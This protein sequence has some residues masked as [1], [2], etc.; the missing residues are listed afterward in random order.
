MK[1]CSRSNSRSGRFDE[2]GAFW[3]KDGAQIYFT[4]LHVDEPYYERPKTE[5]YSVSSNG[6]DATKLNSFDMDVNNMS[7]SPD[8]KQIAF[9]ASATQPVN[10]YTQPDLWVV[11]LT[12][13]A[14]PRNL[15]EKFDF[16]LGSGRFGDKRTPRAGGG[17]VPI[18]TPDGRSLIEIYGKEGKTI[19]ASFDVASGTPTDLTHGNQA[20]VRFR[21]T[22]GS[23]RIVYTIS[24]PTRINDLFVRDRSQAGG[25]PRAANPH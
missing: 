5:L 8:G 22:D 19:L 10:S 13:N 17:N 12:P 16:D 25:E 24:T 14:K 23:R 18:W 1:K 21:A 3:S 15:T 4:S 2:G 11:D 7:L 6:G 9:I 20:V